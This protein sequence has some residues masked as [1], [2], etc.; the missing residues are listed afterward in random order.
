MG[1]RVDVAN[2]FALCSAPCYAPCKVFRGYLQRGCGT[3]D[4]TS[5]VYALRWNT[6][7][8]F[9]GVAISCGSNV[10]LVY[11]VMSI[12]PPPCSLDS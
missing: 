5:V 3:V 7:P 6:R 9:S 11:S 10:R 4:K 8:N 12:Q 1:G 2:A